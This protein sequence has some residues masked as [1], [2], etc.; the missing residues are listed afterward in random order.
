MAAAL[1]RSAVVS[2]QTDN[3]IPLPENVST[4]ARFA[5][6]P[7]P[8]RYYY[9]DDGRMEVIAA[10]GQGRLIARYGGWGAGAQSLD[11]PVGLA[12]GEN[13]VWV[14][15][16]GLNAIVRLDPQLNLITV[17]PLP[18]RGFSHAFIRDAQQRFWI[19]REQAAGLIMVDDGGFK[20]GAAGTELSGASMIQQPTLLAADAG[21]VTVWDESTQELVD[22]DLSGQVYRR[23][24]LDLASTVLAIGRQG[25]SVALLTPDSLMRWDGW[26]LEPVAANAAGW[27]DLV[28]QD[29]RLYLLSAG[30]GLDALPWSP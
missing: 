16:Q 24:T 11:L 1:L 12:A 26:R 2:A 22:I 27:I 29:G 6:A 13:S 5:V 19:A 25:S 15:D 21:G 9:L 14:L 10:D 7:W 8:D 3:F 30:R 17:V 28:L 18:V 20:R 23:V 4:V